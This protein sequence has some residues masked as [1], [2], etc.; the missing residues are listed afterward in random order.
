MKVCL[1]GTYAI[2][3]INRNIIDD[4]DYILESFY[5]IKEWQVK[6]IKDKKLFLLDSGAFTFMSNSHKAVNWN[7]YLDRYI[8]FIKKY[9]IDYFFELDIDAVVGYEKVKEL[10]YRLE[11]QTGKQ[12]IP[13]WHKSRGI[14]E[15]KKICEKY[16][17]IAIGGIVT[18]E[19]KQKEYDKMF[20]LVKYAKS[21]GVKVHGL[22]FTNLKSLENS[23]FFSVDSTSWKSGN[24]FGSLYIF[25]N[26]ELKQIKK[27]DGKRMKTGK[28]YSSV[29][30]FV[31]LEWVKYQKYMEKF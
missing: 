21:K 17:Y 26:G 15:F 7:E 25:K 2:T 31:F 16:K 22:G 8:A 12:C 1:A 4:C 6:H 27:P 10:R 30:K 23:G 20:Q 13:V 11:K 28:Y 24:R 3:P 5:Y 29:E 9:D 18:K 14:E 19:I